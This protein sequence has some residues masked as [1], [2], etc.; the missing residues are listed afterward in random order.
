MEKV[1]RKYSVWEDVHVSF[2]NV[3]KNLVYSGQQ[4]EVLLY[5]MFF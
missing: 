4:Y 3:V 1:V 5:F 2:F